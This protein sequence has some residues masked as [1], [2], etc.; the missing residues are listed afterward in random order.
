MSKVLTTILHSLMKF[1]V[2]IY[3]LPKS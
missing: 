2:R 3:T 1:I